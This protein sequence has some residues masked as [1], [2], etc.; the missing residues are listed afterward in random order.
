[1]REVAIVSFAEVSYPR[2]EDDEV[3]LIT[4]VLGRAMAASGVTKKEIGFTVSGSCDYLGGRPFSFVTAL[5]AI[6]A[7]PPISESH[8][9]M[10]GAWAL[11]EAWVRLQHGDIDAALVYAFGRTSQGE[12]SDVLATQLDPYYLAPLWPDAVSIAALQARAMIDAGLCSER[13]MAEVA[14]LRRRAASSQKASPSAQGAGVDELLAAPYLT[15]PLRSHDCALNSDGA[16]AIVLAAGDLAKRVSRPA[17]IRGID[18]R[19][20]AHAL[21]S[22]DLTRST[23][24]ELAAKKAGALGRHFDIAEIHAPYSHQDILITRALGLGGDVAINP[25]GGAFGANAYIV[26]GLARIGAAASRVLDGSAR[27][28]VA[29]ATSGPCLQQNLVCVLGGER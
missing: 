13:E 22:R 5:D 20:E 9:E 27:S 1:M 26:T 18:H 7:W 12:L 14:L 19:I 15:A 6:G 25:S 23:S 2:S 8:V 3:E 11:Y 17:W 10:D 29:H 16:A 4:G 24:T 21:G 28:A